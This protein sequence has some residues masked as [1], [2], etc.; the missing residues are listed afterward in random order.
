M[1]YLPV[2]IN[3]KE[4]PCLVVGG[5]RVAARKVNTLLKAGARV[6]V[7]AGNFRKSGKKIRCIRRN[8]RRGDAKGYFLVIAATS[9]PAVN[10]AIYTECKKRKIL[11]NTVDVPER[12]DFIFPSI[13][14]RRDLLIAVSTSGSS[15]ALSREI[16]KQIGVIYGPGYGKFLGL[17]AKYRNL[18]KK[19]VSVPGQ[20]KRLINAML[21]P[22]VLKQAANG[23][24][25]RAESL[26]RSTLKKSSKK[27]AEKLKN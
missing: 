20:R 10:R 5:G 21:G 7:I 13:V 16:K 9:D 2:C 27:F 14:Q 22:Q 8:Y 26:I 17:V 6:T 24:Y 19:Y 4:K 18:V 3:I 1:K 25:S 11:V 15:P 23:N 12:C